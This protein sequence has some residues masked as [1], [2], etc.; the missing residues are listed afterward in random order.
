MTIDILCK[1]VDN[2]G[3]I[4]V[5]YRLARA[6]SELDES[7]RLRLIVDDLSAFR[8]LE[9]DIDPGKTVQS[10]RGWTVVGGAGAREPFLA[11][12]PRVVIECFAC[13][14]P[15]WFEEIL[16]DPDDSGERLIVDLEYLTAE[17]FAVEFH[18]LPSLTRSAKVRKAMFMPGFA[19]GTG[20]LIID[21]RF[22]ALRDAYRDEKQRPALR[23]A[24]LDR[25]GAQGGNRTERAFWVSVFCYE[26][27]FSGIVRDLASFHR[28]T[29]V[30]AL[31]AAGRSAGPFMDAW[32]RAGKPF[33][34]FSL[35]F[36]PQETWDEALPAA[37]FS[38]VRGEE[39]LSRAALSGRPFLWQAYPLE[40][41]EHLVKVE[42]LLARLRPR[43]ASGDFALMRSS[44]I[45]FNRGG[46]IALLEILRR[47]VAP[48]PLA[49]GFES[50]SRSLLDLGNLAE[51]LLT[52]IR[53]IG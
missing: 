4:G 7:V 6:L 2:F 31:V 19:S 26:R 27:D 47:S 52:F 46:E 40:K 17:D 12:R 35:P 48:S 37:D 39:S 15:D 16:F 45:S 51:K 36:L 21:R 1:V 9:P 28:E 13:G 41:G 53:E 11:E 22:R 20:G 38:I 32:N 29:P 44:F 3:D 10:V 24:L 33:P 8:A 18:R 42:A 5:A 23:R 14:R 50:W 25:I 43:I 30:F 34:A 49:D